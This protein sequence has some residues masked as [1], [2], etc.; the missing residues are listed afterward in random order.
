MLFPLF[1]VLMIV[2]HAVNAHGSC[3]ANTATVGTSVGATMQNHLCNN[4][5]DES[6]CI[7]Q[8]NRCKWRKELICTETDVKLDE[9]LR[10]KKYNPEKYATRVTF[11]CC[12]KDAKDKCSTKCRTLPVFHAIFRCDHKTILSNFKKFQSH[13]INT[14]ISKHATQLG[15]P[16]SAND[17][18]RHCTAQCPFVIVAQKPDQFP[19]DLTAFVKHAKEKNV[20]TNALHRV[21]EAL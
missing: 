21:M 5:K 17:M 20:R 10:D 12:D 2:P 18:S 6:V 9:W 3:I 8:Q 7:N 13:R 14:Y 15:D 16:Y 11:A 1:F 19:S 4:F